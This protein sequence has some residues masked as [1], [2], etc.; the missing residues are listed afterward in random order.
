MVQHC[1]VFLTIAV[2]IMCCTDVCRLN[3]SFDKRFSI[4]LWVWNRL[5]D[6]F[7]YY[8]LFIINLV[9]FLLTWV[10]WM[11]MLLVKSHSSQI[12]IAYYFIH[13]SALKELNISH[14]ISLDSF[15]H[16][17]KV[18]FKEKNKLRKWI[19]V[20]MYEVCLFAGALCLF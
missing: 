15:L 16:C 4:L 6:L 20:K 9:I 18:Y 13:W 12:V 19:Y 7:Y 3:L 8:S 17:V 11:C 14:N 2:L 1:S 5:R 10:F